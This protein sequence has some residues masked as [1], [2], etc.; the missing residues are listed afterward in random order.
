MSEELEL[1]Q[2]VIDAEDHPIFALD[3]DLRYTA[4][5]RAHA[6]AMREL[7][8]AEITLGGRLADYQPDADFRIARENLLRALAGER[9]VAG[10]FSGNGGRRRSFDVT[11]T[12]RIDGAG[13]VVGVVVRAFDVEEL[14]ESPSRALQTVI[15]TIPDAVYR[16]DRDYRLVFGN[17][18]YAQMIAATRG[19]SIVIGESVLPSD[20]PPDMI[21]E[22]RGCY[23]RAL[24]GES[25]VHDVRFPQGDRVLCFEGSFVPARSSGDA[26][27][28]VVVSIR[29]VTEK[30]RTEAALGG[31]EHSLEAVLGSLGHV[32]AV[33]DE[34]GTILRV[35]P[36]WRLLGVQNDLPEYW[37]REG[38]NYL[39][40]CDAA[41]ARGVEEAARFAAG[42]RAVLAGEA[43]SFTE[44]YLCDTPDGERR[45]EGRVTPFSH[46]G[47]AS[48]VVAHRDVT[49][50]VVAAEELRR[51]ADELR[52]S[53]SRLRAAVDSM[54]D[55]HVLLEAVRDDVA[56]IVDFVFADANAAAC[57]FNGLPCEV[58]VGG[59]LLGQLP[60]AGV[61][62]L[63]R[64]FRVVVE[65]GE[66]L[67]LD[68]WAYP[69]RRAWRRGAHLR[70][71]RRARR[72]RRQRDVA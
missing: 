25:F 31:S 60:A 59:S 4:F 51:G 7:Y 1:L 38:A 69:A 49:D 19:G 23:D 3:R 42:I 57:A 30:K 13:N 9:V 6:A 16:V 18:G 26:V 15:D 71:A 41:A 36:S 33:L 43:D 24:T 2:S 65:G 55:P 63:L 66:P 61:T 10:G 5:N 17:H 44:E 48:V 39:A 40:A 52:R 50:R 27:V 62:E 67:V 29:N 46:A 72:R 21:A 8:G 12:P 20:Y 32:I 11:H 45:F 22:W 54:L 70:R 58:L 14:R 37:R 28:G 68:N 47:T 53:E 56:R 64:L 35:N 34:G